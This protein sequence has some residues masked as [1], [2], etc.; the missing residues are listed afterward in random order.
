MSSIIQCVECK[1]KHELKFSMDFQ[2][3]SLTVMLKTFCSIK[4]SCADILIR[5]LTHTNVSDTHCVFYHQG[6]DILTLM[7]ETEMLVNLNHPIWLSA[8]KNLTE[9]YCYENC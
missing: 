2:T 9:F 8:C 7:L 1:F 4:S 5:W 6:S 3:C